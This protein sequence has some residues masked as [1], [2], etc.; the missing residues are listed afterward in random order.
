MAETMYTR[1]ENE[2]IINIDNWY[3]N[4]TNRKWTL[5]KCSGNGQMS[6]ILTRRR[7]WVQRRGGGGGGGGGRSALGIGL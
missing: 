3:I 5:F 1:F 6:A 7:G 2:P 4:N